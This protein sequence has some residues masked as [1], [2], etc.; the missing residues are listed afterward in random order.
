M[1]SRVATAIGRTKWEVVGGAHYAQL[2]LWEV[3][4]SVRRNLELPDA[5][6]FWGLSRSLSLCCL[7]DLIT[8]GVVRLGMPD[9][10]NTEELRW[11]LSLDDAVGLVAREWVVG[12][13]RRGTAPIAGWVANTEKGSSLVSLV[14]QTGHEH[15]ASI[16]GYGRTKMELVIDSV[17]GDIEPWEVPWLVAR[18]CETLQLD[19]V[20]DLGLRCLQ[21]L[22]SSGLLAVGLRGT[23][24]FAELDSRRSDVWGEVERAMGSDG[25]ALTESIAFRCT[26]H[27][28]RLLADVVSVGPA[29]RDFAHA[30][31]TGG[32][33][34]PSLRP[35]ES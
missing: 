5:G 29:C 34:L 9:P 28:R 23:S 15:Q 21:D 19:A 16:G 11:D 14:L 13:E 12:T 27:G 1:S 26:D 32:D 25:V 18:N 20:Q 30:V 35:L 2:G 3:E 4:R 6:Q 22:V 8:A 33:P 17:F 7:S 10:T 31:N 24:G